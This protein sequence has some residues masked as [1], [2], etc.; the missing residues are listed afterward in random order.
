MCGGENCEMTRVVLEFDDNRRHDG[1]V[2]DHD[3]RH[4]DLRV[5]HV[6]RRRG[7]CPHRNAPGQPAHG[8][9]PGKRRR[10]HAGPYQGCIAARVSRVECSECGK[11]LPAEA[12]RARPE[13]RMTRRMEA[14]LVSRCKRSSTRGVALECD[15]SGYRIRHAPKHCIDEAR[16][17]AGHSGV[18]TVGIG[19]TSTCKGRH[20]IAAVAEAKT[21]RTASACEGRGRETV[22]FFAEDLGRHGGDP[23]AIDKACID[24]SPACISG[25]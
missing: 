3:K 12:P 11:V 25:V 21:G 7:D 14:L 15:I 5:A 18:T 6:R 8:T 2:F 22:G 4:V 1:F 24:M 10:P 9:K 19:E 13:S 17:K 20:C 16:E 23:L